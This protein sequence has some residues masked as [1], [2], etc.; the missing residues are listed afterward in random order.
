[1]GQEELAARCDAHKQAGNSQ[2][3]GADQAIKLQVHHL[4]SFNVLQLEVDTAL[5]EQLLGSSNVVCIAINAEH[6]LKTLGQLK[7]N[8]ASATPNVD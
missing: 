1:M 4:C 8:T 3:M 6:D 5:Q 2:K 7:A